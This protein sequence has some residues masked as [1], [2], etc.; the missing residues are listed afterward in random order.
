MSLSVVLGPAEGVCVFVSLVIHFLVLCNL[1]VWVPWTAGQFDTVLNVAA[2]VGAVG[3]AVKAV[4]SSMWSE[5]VL[6]YVASAAGGRSGTAV[7]LPGMAVVVQVMVTPVVC[8]GEDC[9]PLAL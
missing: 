2:D 1:C 5:H 3:H 7:H 6:T 9:V 8:A 4:W